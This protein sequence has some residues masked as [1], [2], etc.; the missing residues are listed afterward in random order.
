MFQDMDK[1]IYQ[2]QY[3]VVECKPVIQSDSPERRCRY[4]GL[5]ATDQTGVHACMS[6]IYFVAKMILREASAVIV[7]LMLI[8]L[9]SERL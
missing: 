9:R 1:E 2:P 3:R 7:V 6:L 8:W 5:E 4:N